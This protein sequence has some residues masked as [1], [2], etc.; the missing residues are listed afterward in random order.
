[1]TQ[2]NGSASAMAGGK[3]EFLHLPSIPMA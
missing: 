3:P 2:I 1:L